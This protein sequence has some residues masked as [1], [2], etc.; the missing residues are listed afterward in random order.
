MVVCRALESVCFASTGGG[1]ERRPAWN[2][3]SSGR[4]Q[5]RPRPE[6][7]SWDLDGVFSDASHLDVKFVIWL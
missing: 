2:A 4:S 7:F 3:R 6:R 5:E 1:A